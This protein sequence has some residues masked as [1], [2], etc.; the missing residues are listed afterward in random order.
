MR[1]QPAVGLGL[2]D[3]GVPQDARLDEAIAICRRV[4]EQD[5]LA[6]RAYFHAAVALNASSRFVEAEAACRT[7][8]ELSPEM[9]AVHSQLAAILMAMGRGEDALAEALLE[10]DESYRLIALAIVHYA[11]GRH[12]ESDRALHMIERTTNAYQIG[13]IH[14]VR[15]ERD[16]AFEC[17]ERAFEQHNAGMP[18]LKIDRRLRSLHGDPRYA[19]LLEKMRFP[20]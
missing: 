10:P 5:P 4:A 2:L 3:A 11:A 17:L 13:A 18:S 12:E 7:A 8:L 9:V 14:A 1:A 6:A 15:G 16:E 19:A 20:G